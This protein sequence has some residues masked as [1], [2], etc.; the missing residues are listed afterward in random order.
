MSEI[1]NDRTGSHWTGPDWLWLGE[2]LVVQ[3]A[4]LKQRHCGACKQAARLLEN[5]ITQAATKIRREKTVEVKERGGG[6]LHHPIGREGRKA[7]SQPRG[8]AVLNPS[9]SFIPRPGQG[10]GEGREG[11]RSRPQRS[12]PNL[13]RGSDQVEHPRGETHQS[14]TTIRQGCTN[15]HGGTIK[16]RTPPPPCWLVAVNIHESHSS[17]SFQFRRTTHPVPAPTEEVGVGGADLPLLTLDGKGCKM[18]PSSCRPVS[19]R[20]GYCL[21]L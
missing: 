5:T 2:K 10:R 21:G 1:R 3:T 19:A 16:Y 4:E 12:P 6:G 9:R 13:E 8:S 20:W 11:G 18:T 14:T 17:T 15:K 7:A